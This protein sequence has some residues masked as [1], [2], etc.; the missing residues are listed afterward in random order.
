VDG[1]LS[2]GDRLPSCGLL[3]EQFATAR[4]TVDA[5]YAMLAGEG[6]VVSRGRQSDQFVPLVPTG[7]NQVNLRSQDAVRTSK[8]LVN[9]IVERSNR[10]VL[11]VAA[12]HNG[13]QL[14]T[15]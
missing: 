4:G 12:A 2:P 11:F 15:R 6:Y 13:S 9:P 14:S 8:E 10:I 1:Q 3:A 5:A 7:N